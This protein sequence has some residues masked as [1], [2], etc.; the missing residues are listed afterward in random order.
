MAAKK[1][2]EEK[3]AEVVL[4]PFAYA[5]A[6]DGEVVQLVKGNAVDAERYVRSSLEHLRALGF[7]GTN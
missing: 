6:K 2:S 4:V 1:S 5:T 3:P 7:I